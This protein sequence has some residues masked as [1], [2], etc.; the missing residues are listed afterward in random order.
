[1]GEPIL[2]KLKKP[3]MMKI[4]NLLQNCIKTTLCVCVCVC[5]RVCRLGL[6][7]NIVKPLK[8]TVEKS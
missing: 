7:T 3:K 8:F 5:V 6:C 1:M 4:I 2:T